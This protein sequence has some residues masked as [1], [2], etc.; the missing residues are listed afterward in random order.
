MGIKQRIALIAGFILILSAMFFF[1]KSIIDEFTLNPER[2]ELY[3]HKESEI[4]SAILAEEEYIT[5]KYTVAYEEMENNSNNN[6]FIISIQKIANN[7]DE[8]FKDKF[9]DYLKIKIPYIDEDTLNI[10]DYSNNNRVL[11][12]WHKGTKLFIASLLFVLLV[13][14]FIRKVKIIKNHVKEELKIHYIKEVIKLRISEI[15]EE[16]IKLV[17]LMF[18]GIFLLQWII[19]F[20]FNIPGKYLPANDIFD[21]KFYQNLSN[22]TKM[23]LS[24]Y[25][26]L[27]DSTLNKVKLLSLGIFIL[28]TI[29]LLV[30]IRA[31]N[32]ELL[33]GRD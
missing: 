23:G 31:F 20:Q 27:F 8:F 16:A 5:E 12:E 22:A 26:C 1:Q 11:A 10:R 13:I 7:E 14:I 32:N 25:G 19:K 17:V 2:L 6:A 9:I 29:T 28:G 33:R 15:L 30:T 4:L 18:G 24:S 21:F 3:F